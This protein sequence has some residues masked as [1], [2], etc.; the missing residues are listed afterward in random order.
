MDRL[1]AMRVFVTVAEKASF[2]AA[3]R[4]LG[5]SPPAVTRAVAGLE[6]RIGTALLRR[7]T[8]IVRVTEAGERYLVDCRRILAEID[9]ADA[10]AAG[11]HA[12]PRGLVTVTAPVVFGRIYVAP[13]VLELLRRHPGVSV[14]TL[15]L[16]RVVDMLEERVD[17]AVRIAHL[18]DSS[19]SALRV[20]SVR[21]VVCAAPGYLS[22]RGVPRVPGDLVDHDAIAFSAASTPPE[23]TFGDGASAATVRVRSRLLVNTAELA[24]DAALAGHGVT[25]VL[26]YQVAQHVAAGTLRIVLEAAEPPAV[27]IHVVHHEGRRASARVRAFV[28]LAAERLRA[29]DVLAGR[30]RGRRGRRS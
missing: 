12:Q 15:L 29:D 6:E 2:A 24:I 8:R 23:W 9:E 13:I 5:L 11:A 4:G 18:P 16:D 17:V 10:S 14:R 30:A 7:T 1:E 19:S 28:D 20:G 3:A 21:R 22:R 25:R 27:P 26:S